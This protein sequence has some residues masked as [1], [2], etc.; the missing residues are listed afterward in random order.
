MIRRTNKNYSIR[1]YI[2]ALSS[3]LSKVIKHLRCRSCLRLAFLLYGHDRGIGESRLGHADDRCTK[4]SGLGGVGVDGAARQASQRNLIV[5]CVYF[6][7]DFLS[8]N[9]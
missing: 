5:L 8:L 4:T 2:N 9:L 6:E 1:V 7:T 3:R